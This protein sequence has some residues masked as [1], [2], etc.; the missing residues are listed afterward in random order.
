MTYEF[1]KYSTKKEGLSE[2][3]IKY[4]VAIIPNVLNAI[5]CK[6]MVNGMWSY[7]EHIT[8]MWTV[9]ID[10]HNK[11]TWTEFYKL[12]PVHSMLIQHW[13]VG[14]NQESWNLRQ[15]EKIVNIFSYFWN[16]DKDNL[17]VSFDGLSF[18]LP[19]ETTNKGWNRDNTWYHTDQSYTRNT[20][21]CIQSWITGLDVN[22][23]DATLSIME[24]SHKYHEEFSKKFKITDKSDWYKLNKMEEQFY[25]NKGCEY[26]NI[27]C[28]KGSL[29]FWDSRTIHCG[30]E[31][32]NNRLKSNIRAVI[33][34][35]Y[36]PRDYC[37]QKQLEK[38]QKAFLE[39]RTTVHHPCKPK[40]FPKKPNTYGKSIE[41]IT[42]INK[43]VLNE[44]G[45][46]LAGF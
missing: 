14:H 40:L 30:I 10:R 20:F 17:L 22:E 41:E 12:Y 39:L 18:N 27:K 16:T 23:G 46:K 1:L 11:K 25:I 34:L 37:K 43:P 9:P 32:H 21:E 4:G 7:F 15:N 19:P 8:S 2:M 31:A 29:V 45:K 42:I 35:C 26:K 36:S 24:N 28:P 5:E 3:M 44:L 6:K 33:Y 38:K 13:N